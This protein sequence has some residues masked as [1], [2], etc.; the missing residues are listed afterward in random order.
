MV[1]WILPVCFILVFFTWS[2][3]IFCQHSLKKLEH[4]VN[5]NHLD[6]I[7]P[8]VSYDESVLY[9][10]RVADPD[11][12]RTLIV[13][14]VDVH[15]TL[16]SDQYHRLVGEVYSQIASSTIKDA[17][18][19]TFNQ[20]IW[21]THLKN[22][23][24]DGIFH[25][26]YPVNDVLPN[27]ICS[28]FGKNNTYLV[29]NKFQKN[30][31][32][33]KGFS[34]IEKIN[35]TFSF[36]SPIEIDGF[37]A[38]STEVNITA[39]LDSSII[40]ISMVQP[41]DVQNM[42]L[43]YAKKIGPNHYSKPINLGEGVNSSF[44]ESTPMLSHDLQRLYFTSDRPN[45][46]GGKDIYFCEKI[47]P[48]NFVWSNPTLLTP[49][50]NSPYDDAHPHLMKDNKTIFFTSNR[51]GTSDIYKA[52][53]HRDVIKNDL[54]ITILIKNGN[55]N[56]LCSGELSWGEAYQKERPG[57]FRAKNGKCKYQFF[58]NKAMVFKAKN[59]SLESAEVIVDPQEILDQGKKEVVIEL[60]LFE[61]SET[62]L[63][64]EM[65]NYEF[66][67]HDSEKKIGQT[68][69]LNNI[70]FERTKPTVLPVSYASIQKL[71]DVLLRHPSMSISILGH[72]DNTGDKKAN[73]QLSEKRA[74]AIKSI[75]I[76]KGIQSQ[77]IKALGYGDTAPI[78]PN[79][80]EENKRKN[81]RVEVKI[82]SR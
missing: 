21:Y 68:V 16:A 70:Y 18:T 67:A 80:T 81:R 61:Q 19:S 34:I 30:G 56:Q 50:V 77:R 72:T 55:T 7:C 43:Y 22:S 37:N 2:N 45:G 8:I 3:S 78:A 10:T 24:P 20:D 41:S 6:E 14:D 53:L 44:R 25:P 13:N 73:K 23:E 52:K 17:F 82:E 74:E 49:P 58:A 46:Y 36:P 63:A 32:I 59:R 35:D 38:T 60:Y 1:K 69:T 11:C 54:F 66:E 51:D 75:L 12:R 47:D 48:N 29:I 76:E 5:T 71:A 64:T 40:I 39:S 9:F 62:I 26:D 57:F 33:D 28:N 31:G 4:P 65:Q 27:S 79:D 15:K 42:D